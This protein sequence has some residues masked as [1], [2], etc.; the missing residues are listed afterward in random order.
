MARG[1]DLMGLGLSHILAARVGMNVQAVTIAGT[2][3]GS[4]TQ[5]PGRQGIYYVLA[6]NSGSGIKLPPVGGLN[7]CLP[8]DEY[9]IVNNQGATLAV[10]AANNASGSAV[11]LIGNGAATAGTT[12]VSLL[13]AHV[14]IYKNIN[15]STWAFVKTSV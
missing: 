3:V 4:A 12:G 15:A 11:T 8:T 7:G 5:L 14:A 1:Q 2:S 10:Y 9:T 13:T 6:S